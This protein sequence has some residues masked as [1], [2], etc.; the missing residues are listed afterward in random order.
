MVIMQ[1][2]AYT[3]PCRFSLL[4]TLTLLSSHLDDFQNS[5]RFRKFL[6]ISQRK[7]A[8]STCLH[9]CADIS[10]LFHERKLFAEGKF[11]AFSQ[12]PK[13]GKLS[14]L[15]LVFKQKNASTLLSFQLKFCSPMKPSAAVLAFK[16]PVSLVPLAPAMQ[17]T[18]NIQLRYSNAVSA[19][20]DLA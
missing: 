10:K 2:S 7:C 5:H 8:P 17:M 18:F 16:T 15:G 19:S 11:T 14:L 9:N 12:W 3:L 13:F 6:G 1:V 20:A 4:V